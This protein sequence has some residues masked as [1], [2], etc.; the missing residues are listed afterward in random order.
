[1]SDLDSYFK[2]DKRER[3]SHPLIR[4]FDVHQGK[5]EFGK[6]KVQIIRP[7][8]AL[9]FESVAIVPSVLQQAG[10]DV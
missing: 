8:A 2:I 5:P 1:M 4:L 9:G 3:D 7:R 6:A 10:R